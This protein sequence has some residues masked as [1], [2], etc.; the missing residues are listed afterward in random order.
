M[1]V[2]C[3]GALPASACC[4]R[5]IL[6]QAPRP[7][8]AEGTKVRSEPP[9]DAAGEPGHHHRPDQHPDSHP[10][11]SQEEGRQGQEGA[12]V[13]R[14]NRTPSSVL[15]TCWFIPASI[16]PPPPPALRPLFD[17]RATSER[18]VRTGRLS[19]SDK[20]RPMGPT[21]LPPPPPRRARTTSRRTPLASCASC[22]RG[23]ELMP[24]VARYGDWWMGWGWGVSVDDFGRTR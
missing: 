10:Q 5:L 15:A 17:A 18:R 23:L 7:L 1:E 22:A 11:P 3:Q 20:R 16:P 24:P 14:E 19:P 13:T 2:G 21:P 12:R 8:W 9:D 4:M 6:S